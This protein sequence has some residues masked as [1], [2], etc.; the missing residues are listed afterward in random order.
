MWPTAGGM[1]CHWLR[2]Q[3]LVGMQALG[4][5][6]CPSSC[7]GEGQ[8]KRVVGQHSGVKRGI[9]LVRHE[10]GGAGG[11]AIPLTS[12]EY[13][14]EGSDLVEVVGAVKPGLVHYSRCWHRLCRI[15]I[16]QGLP[17]LQHSH[18]SSHHHRSSHNR[19]CSAQG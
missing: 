6:R 12:D 9:P 16:V 8:H 18:H 19:V 13:G 15:Y 14:E 10:R 1:S 17:C 7:T 5:S 4:Y 3:L 11:A 2:K